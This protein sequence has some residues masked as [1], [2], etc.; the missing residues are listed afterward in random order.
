MSAQFQ[1]ERTSAEVEYLRVPPHDI[2]AEQAVLGALM[3]MPV[4]L[5]KIQDWLVEDDF[6]R[7][8]HRLIYRAICGLIGRG[9]PVD[10][11]TLS[12]WLESNDLAELVGGSNYVFEL[13]SN[14]PSAANIVAYAEIV[15]EKSKCRRVI[16]IGT[17]LSERGYVAKLESQ[18]ILADAQYALGQI[19]ASKLRASLVTA[20]GAMAR[21]Y[22]D[23]MERYERGGG[24]S[25][26]PTPWKAINEW[27]NG[28]EPGTLSL[29]GA[30]PSM[31][32]SAFALQTA[33][34]AASLGHRTAFFSVEMSDK[35]CMQ[36]AVACWGNIPLAWLR[37]PKND[38]PD[39]EMYWSRLERATAD[40]LAMPFLIDAT[41]ALTRTQLDA[42]CRRAHMQAPLKLVIVDHIHDMKLDP[43]REARFELGDIAQM[44]K[45]IAKEL[46]CHVIMLGQLNR[47]LEQRANKRP[48]MADFRESG[49]LEQKADIMMALYRDVIYDPQTPFRDVVEVLRLKGRDIGIGAPI[50]LQSQLDVMRMEN[51]IGPL[52]VDDRSSQSSSYRGMR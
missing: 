2:G 8:D 42:R 38:D 41:P 31:G 15:A 20:K 17:T 24:L 50:M 1:P 26:I 6:Y 12:E 37:D 43:K 3:L 36:R 16:D 34:H 13:H 4:S 5:A 44:G 21:M 19:Q 29:V 9:D 45:T 49:E 23:L 28:L 51:W 47:S 40:I 35:Q 22:A 33:L 52:P 27:T 30:R 32:K 10:T 48:I 18:Q 14:T 25:G 11:V 39:A 46:E 7:K